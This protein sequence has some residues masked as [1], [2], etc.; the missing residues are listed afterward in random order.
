MP[1]VPTS[2]ADLAPVRCGPVISA[3]PFNFD[4]QPPTQEPRP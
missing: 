4:P 3:A 1:S 2:H